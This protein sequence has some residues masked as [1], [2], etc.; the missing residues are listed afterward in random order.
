MFVLIHLGGHFSRSTFK[1][2]HLLQQCLY[3]I[4]PTGQME[5]LIWNMT[6][7]FSCLEVQLVA[8]TDFIFAFYYFIFVYCLFYICILFFF[9][10]YI[11]YIYIYK[12][13]I[14]LLKSAEIILKN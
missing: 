6:A 10:I 3:A 5:G 13:T 4:G 2:L 8:G 1:E 11:H 7:R 9:I 12:Q 14:L